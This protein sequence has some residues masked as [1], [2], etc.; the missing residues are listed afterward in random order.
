MPFLGL[1]LHKALYA[2]SKR[3]TVKE[4]D[5]FSVCVCVC[6]CVCM[7][8]CVCVWCYC[9]HQYNLVCQLPVLLLACFS[10]NKFVL[11]GCFFVGSCAPV[12]R[13]IS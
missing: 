11:I 13:N 12:W 9:C 3:W 7:C 4:K 2:D 6:V 8:V 5:L 10:V 1:G